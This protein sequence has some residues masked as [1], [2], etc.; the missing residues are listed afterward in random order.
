[1]K[2]IPAAYWR[3]GGAQNGE[4]NK[5]QKVKVGKKSNEI[6]KLTK[7]NVGT[8]CSGPLDPHQILL[9]DPYSVLHSQCGSGS[10]VFFLI[11]RQIH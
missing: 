11:F 6:Q 1:M 9:L 4:K 5:E 8:S 3:G 2:A 10:R 7:N